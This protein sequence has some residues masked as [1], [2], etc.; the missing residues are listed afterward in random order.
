MKLIRKTDCLSLPEFVKE[1][2]KR[3]ENLEKINNVIIEIK[4]E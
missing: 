1:L 3:I 2:E 4:G